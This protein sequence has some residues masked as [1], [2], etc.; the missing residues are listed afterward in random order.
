MVTQE[1]RVRLEAYFVSVSRQ[2]QGRRHCQL[3]L[4]HNEGAPAAF[5]SSAVVCACAD[6]LL[7]ELSDWVVRPMGLRFC[8]LNKGLGLGAIT[9]YVVV[10]RSF[11]LIKVLRIR[12]PF[13]KPSYLLG[14]DSQKLGDTVV[15]VMVVGVRSGLIGQTGKL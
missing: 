2:W 10:W 4:V 6:A 7:L 14:W 3:K 13:K 8:L 1:M 15:F 5:D 9:S 11:F 12:A